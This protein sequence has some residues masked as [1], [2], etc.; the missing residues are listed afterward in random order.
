MTRIAVDYV[1]HRFVTRKATEDEWDRDDTAANI[2][3]RGIQKV[4]DRNGY[5]DLEV[6]FDVDDNTAY[7]LLWADY[8]TAD[9]FG[10][11]DNQLEIIDLFQTREAAEKAKEELLEETSSAY[12]RDNGIQIVYDKPWNGYFEH[13]NE[14][15]VEL[16]RVNK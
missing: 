5:A 15:H 12:T 3:V 1:Q 9:S 2:Y 11:D 6:D 10:M 14:L 16:V 8:S 4:S 7:Y 13:L